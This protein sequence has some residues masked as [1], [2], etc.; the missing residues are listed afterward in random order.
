MIKPIQISCISWSDIMDSVG[1]G[2]KVVCFNDFS[3]GDAEHT[4]VHPNVVLAELENHLGD[5]WE[6]LEA[7]EVTLL[8]MAM[9]G[10]STAFLICFD[11]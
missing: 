11:G 10:L 9:R 4:L 2:G 6:D 7:E 5:S 1:L 3:W 8:C